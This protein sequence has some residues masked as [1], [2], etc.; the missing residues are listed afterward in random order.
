[1]LVFLVAGGA[2]FVVARR[3]HRV[4]LNGLSCSSNQLRSTVI[5]YTWTS[6]PS[7]PEDALGAFLH[8][9]H[10]KD[11]PTSGYVRPSLPHQR[12]GDVAP[13]VQQPFDYVHATHGHVDVGLRIE[14]SGGIWEVSEVRACA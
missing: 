11:L 10:A 13:S 7:S 4:E 8:S 2:W 6:G 1:V 14:K 9:A 5:D 12:T 3:H